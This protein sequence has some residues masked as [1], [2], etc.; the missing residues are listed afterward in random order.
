MP[1]CEHTPTEPRT[2]IGEISVMYAPATI[3]AT[4][5]TTPMAV[6]GLASLSDCGEHHPEPTASK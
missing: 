5:A 1:T 4:P 2:P 6:H 3:C